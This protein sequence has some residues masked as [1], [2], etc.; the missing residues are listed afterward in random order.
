MAFVQEQHNVSL[1]EGETSHNGLSFRQQKRNQKIM[2]YGLL[3]DTCDC[4]SCVQQLEC[5][6]HSLG[7]PNDGHTV[8]N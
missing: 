3:L 2:G 4:D 5:L 8:M 1:L 6:H 7:S